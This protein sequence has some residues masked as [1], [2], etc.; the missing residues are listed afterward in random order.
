MN[1]VEFS[2]QAVSMFLIKHFRRRTIFLTYGIMLASL[3]SILALT[4][5]ANQ[6]FLA[7]ISFLLMVFTFEC[8]GQPIM[9]LYAVEITTNAASGVLFFYGQVFMML[10][11][12]GIKW[13]VH[14]LDVSLLFFISSG[15]T[16]VFSV[17]VFLFI[18]ETF[19]LTDK[20][21]KSL[22]SLEKKDQ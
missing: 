18:K 2:S 8:F 22:Y 1:V 4:D 12:I 9:Q 7:L 3:N 14:D 17:L 5:L 10:A 20:E 19:D 6:N 13:M 21:K 11:G 15:I 16:A